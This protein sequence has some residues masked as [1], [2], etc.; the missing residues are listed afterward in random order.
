MGESVPDGKNPT[1]EDI[2]RNEPDECDRC[3]DYVLQETCYVSHCSIVTLALVK[4][5]LSSKYNLS[6][7]VSTAHSV[8][9]N[10]VQQSWHP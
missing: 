3:F 9:S 2:H 6:T 1:P 8:V 7:P 10:P 5:K 4:Y